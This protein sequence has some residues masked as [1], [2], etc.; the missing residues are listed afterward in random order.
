M[1]GIACKL[2]SPREYSMPPLC[3]ITMPIKDSYFNSKKILFLALHHLLYCSI[4][5]LRNMA[6]VGSWYT[7]YFS[8]DFQNVEKKPARLLPFVVRGLSTAVEKV[9][10]LERQLG[11]P[12]F[13]HPVV[14]HCTPDYLMVRKKKIWTSK[15]THRLKFY[16]KYS[17][18]EQ[19]EFFN[20]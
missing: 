15:T 18:T 4:L 11:S 1:D 16:S 5:V 12:G 3:Y 14:L 9:W 20:V 13:Y 6:H 17:E 10:E 19:G 2:F 7:L 8:A